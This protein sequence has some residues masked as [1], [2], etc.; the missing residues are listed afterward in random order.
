MIINRVPKNIVIVE[1]VMYNAIFIDNLGLSK[2]V[3]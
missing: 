2:H 3:D 1:C